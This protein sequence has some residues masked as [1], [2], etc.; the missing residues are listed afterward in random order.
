LVKEIIYLHGA[1]KSVKPFFD[2][3]FHFQKTP[4]H[5]FKLSPCLRLF[6]FDF[7]EIE[8]DPDF[9]CPRS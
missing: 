9:D 2:Y 7:L 5:S 1:K 3:D 6:G 4:A 8:I